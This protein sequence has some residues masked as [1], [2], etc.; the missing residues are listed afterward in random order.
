MFSYWL[1]KSEPTTFSIT[2]LQQSIEQT[3]FWDGVRNYQA[4]NYLR[5]TKKGDIVFFYHS[6]CEKLGIYGTAIVVQEAYPDQSQ[7]D[8]KS[9]HYDPQSRE[10]N[11]RWFGVEIKLTQLFQ[12][13]IL[14]ADI[15]R[16]PKLE[17]MVLVQKGSR[18]SVQPI[19]NQEA[20]EMMRMAQSSSTKH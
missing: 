9:E 2:H 3:T 4:R 6:N 13:P 12:K 19:T 8:A 20:E 17:K 1:F 7:F 18:L 16:N 14:L 11:P 10:N 5:A 15:K